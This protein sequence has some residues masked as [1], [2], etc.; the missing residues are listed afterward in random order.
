MIKR[1]IIFLSAVCLS[2]AV[3]S[4]QT[5]SQTANANQTVTAPDIE[6]SQLNKKIAENINIRWHSIEYEKTLYNPAPGAVQ[7]NPAQTSNKQSRPRAESLS[8][9]FDV[10]TLG[11]GPILSACPDAVIEQITDSRGNNI[12]SAPFSS[13]SSLMY[14]YVPSVHGNIMT[15]EQPDRPEL[16]TLR[17]R[18][19]AN[20][21]EQI[22]GEI[23]LKG[24]FYALVA[25]SLEY[26]EL[27]FKPSDKWV[28][29]TPEVE[30][31][32]RK[33]R[34]EASQYLYDIEQRPENV[35]DL[36][37][38]Q[39]GDYLPSR[40]IVD[41]QFIGKTSAAG[42]GG[43]HS[44]GRIG[45]EGDGIGR[46]EKIC[47]II[48]V[49]PAHQMI[50]FD[51]KRIPLSDIVKPVPS[52]TNNSNRLKPAPVGRQMQNITHRS[53][54]SGAQ[55]MPEQ[56]KP[57]FDKKVAD[58]FEV[59]WNYITYRKTLYNTSGSGKNRNQRLSEKLSVQCEA[60]ILDPKMIVGTC[61]IPVIEQ[62]MDGNGRD[63]DISIT[64]S[65]SNRMCYSSLQYQPSLIPTLP[66]SLIYWEGRARLALGLPLQRR[67]FPK[68]TL[69][70]QPVHMKIELDPGLLRRDAGEIGSIK[71]Y[72]QALSA[73]SFK[74]IEVPFKPDNKWV[75]LTSDVEIQ[76]RK[77]WHTG[78]EARYDIRQL[79]RTGA[80]SH[81]LFVGGSLPDGIVM[82]RQFIVK[83]R[84]PEPPIKFGHSL[85]ASIGG[86]GSCDIGQ[87]IE[88]IDY[89][90]A[91]DPNHNRIPF[92]FK[93]IPLP[94]P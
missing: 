20:L 60:K 39:I 63:A 22:N 33:A 83:D 93:H 29:L 1:K 58:C 90:I 75:R 91:V 76:V 43:G 26:V 2:I 82:E 11:S 54:G 86:S 5:L 38:V 69:V 65:R 16:S 74:H 35:T 72:F 77:A 23:G 52:Q 10:E 42:A 94:K 36:S 64:Q 57:Q 50:P 30:V 88:K 14:I 41:R 84:R 53:T 80:G 4:F 12:E 40:L 51:I 31:R 15:V 61:D 48:A 18:L 92:E 71:G 56:V 78:T 89:L 62:I 55:R 44:T 34:Y 25:E 7:G 8:L 9:S 66:S 21:L 45:G 3:F 19:D 28:R 85:T 70:L 27:P 81:D 68:H 24:H 79:G 67:H 37:R 73:G 49:N 6:G 59:N 87:Q 17:V 32:V 47:Y 46:A 13:R